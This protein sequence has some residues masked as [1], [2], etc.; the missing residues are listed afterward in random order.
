M[1]RRQPIE[2]KVNHERWLVSY[3]D[4]ITLL[5][6]FFVVMYSISQVNESKYKVLSETLEQVFSDNVFVQSNLK[7]GDS[8]KL[9]SS[10]IPDVPAKLNQIQEQMITALSGMVKEGDVTLSGNEQWIEIALSANIL[11]QSGQ[12]KP[13]ADAKRIFADIAQVLAPHANAIAVAGHTDTIP[14][15]NSQFSNNWELSAARSVA[16]VSLLAYQGVSPERMSAVG[17]GEHHPIADNTTPEGRKRNRRVV[18]RIAKDAVKLP[19]EP[20]DQVFPALD[21]KVDKEQ[22][23]SDSDVTPLLE[24]QVKNPATNRQSHS[25]TSRANSNA[26]NRLYKGI[27]PVKLKSGGLLFSS[28][29][30]LPRNNAPIDSDPESNSN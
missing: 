15:N 11:F 22:N 24:S 10:S 27:E 23:Q 28:D 8:D 26:K 25:D 2:T 3:A 17:Y 1:I 4:F 30:Q 12:A 20:M 14:I 7:E 21:S 19:A 6:A 9:F 13:S 18:L 16:I 5:F 29:P